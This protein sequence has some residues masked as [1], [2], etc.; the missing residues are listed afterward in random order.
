M[1]SAASQ[2]LFRLRATYV[3]TATA[4]V[5]ASSTTHRFFSLSSQR[6]NEE[7]K[8][9][10]PADVT[11]EAEAEA[12]AAPAEEEPKEPVKLSR[13]RRRF[14]EWVKEDGARFVR[15]SQGTTNYIGA[16][17]FPNNPLFQPRPP[18]SDQRRQEIYETFAANPEDWSIR[19]LATK[20]GISM[21]RV[22]A[23]LKLK[24]SELVLKTNATQILRE[25]LVDIFP[26]VKKPTF[27]LVDEHSTFT[28]KDAA[29]VLNRK[30][31]HVLE[32]NAIAM[33]EAKFSKS[34][35]Q[36]ASAPAVSKQKRFVIVD[37]SK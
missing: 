3:P 34:R 18:L 27:K 1:L 36:Q 8:K 20:F 32:E 25:P 21:R 31:I 26:K 6:W 14:H 35:Q 9:E 30:P 11:V 7:E 4:A 29:K 2:Y 16:T 22:E 37:T 12:E 19:K 5:A 33:E 23:V 10:Q 28:E 17:P 24:E 13:R 15:P